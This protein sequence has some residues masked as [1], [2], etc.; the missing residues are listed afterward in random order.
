M[1]CWG[2]KILSVVRRAGL[3][4]GQA[5]PFSEFSCTRLCAKVRPRRQ[6][7]PPTFPPLR[8]RLRLSSSPA[9]SVT[10]TTP[11]PLLYICSSSSCLQT[12]GLQDMEQEVAQPSG[13]SAELGMGRCHSLCQRSHR[14]GLGTESSST[15]CEQGVSSPSPT[16]SGSK[17]HSLQK[18]RP[19]FLSRS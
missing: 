8:L 4:T 9:P 6:E 15:S 7:S 19:S 3:R 14:D 13:P 10:P 17:G 12:K 16:S 2:S 1:Q 11:Q 18:K 5:L